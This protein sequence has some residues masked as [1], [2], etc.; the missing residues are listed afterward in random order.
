MTR[1]GTGASRAGAD[2]KARE[3][4]PDRGLF[5]DPHG[6]A[7]QEKIRTIIV[8]DHE[9]L[10]VLV[11]DRIAA[12]IRERNAAGKPAVLGLAT[13]STPIGVYRELVRKHREEGLSFKHVVTFNLDEYWPM[14][15]DSIHSYHRFMWENL[16]SQVD[17]DP[18]NVHI[19]DGTVSRDVVEE[20]GDKYERAIRDAGGIDFQILGIGKT[21]HIGF[22]EPGSGADSRTRLVTLDT[23]TRRDAAADFF[24]EEYVPREAITMGVA[25]IMDAREIAI[26]ATGEHKASIVRRAVEGEIDVEVAATFLQRHP[27]TTF[28]LDHASAA[29]LTR[30]ATPWLI[31]EVKW[32]QDLMVRAVIWLSGQTDKAILKLTQRDYSDHKLSSLVAKHGTPGEVNGKA[33]NI[34]GAKIRGKSKLP[35]HQRIICFS[36]HPDDD[37]ISIGGILHKLVENE[38][39]VVVAYMTSGNIA[40]FDHDVRRYVDFLERMGGEGALESKTVTALARKAHQFL[41]RKRSEE[42]TSELQS[43]S[44]LVCR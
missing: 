38:N 34:L 10:G 15:K 3:R 43:Q 4:S 35:T 41:E 42:H 16:F 29:E 36:P 26:L 39:E 24:G 32:T 23:V 9:E 40:V 31:D 37:V 44:N 11:A 7:G 6:S 14:P 5:H 28:Y 2:V 30:I 8:E 33:F 21:G 27:S 18:V 1:S 25:T 20:Y 17:I 19:P 13:G 12:V 22:N